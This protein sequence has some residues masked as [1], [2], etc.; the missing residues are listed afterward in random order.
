LCGTTSIRRRADNGEVRRPAI[1][2]ALVFFVLAAAPAGAATTGGTSAPSGGTSA[3]TGTP[4][5]SGPAAGGGSRGSNGGTTVDPAWVPSGGGGPA[6]GT[7]PSAPPPTDTGDADGPVRS[8][9]RT[10]VP[11][12]YLRIYRAAA[13]RYGVDWRLLAAIGKN[14]SDHGRAQLPG[15]VSGLNFAECCSGPMQICQVESCGNVWDAYRQDA[16]AD[17]VESIYSPA[18]AIHAAAALVVDLRRIVGPNPRLVMAAYNAGPGNVQ[19]YRGI[20][21]FAETLVYVRSGIRYIR[22]LRG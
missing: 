4:A 10:D 7:T 11:A 8:F 15:V 19:R 5:P 9:A 14:E 17:G 21:P 18:D 6:G 22:A 20:P 2:T 16:D 12:P 13:R 3:G 1:V